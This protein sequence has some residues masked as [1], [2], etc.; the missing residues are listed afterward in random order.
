MWTHIAFLYTLV[1]RISITKKICSIFIKIAKSKKLFYYAKK[2]ETPTRI[3]EGLIFQSQYYKTAFYT[4][5]N[6]LK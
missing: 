5:K 2:I 1:F 4:N 3:C 6:E